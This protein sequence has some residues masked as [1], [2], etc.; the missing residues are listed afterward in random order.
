MRW[1]SLHVFAVLGVAV[2]LAQA[3]AQTRTAAGIEAF[4]RGDYQLAVEILKP[5]AETWSPRD[6]V[7]EFFMATLYE[8]GRGITADPVRACALYVRASFDRENAIGL[9]AAALVESL[10]R[11]LSPEGFRQCVQLANI[12]FEHGFQPVTFT[13][14]QGHWIS[15][16]LDGATVTF[17][18]TDKRSNLPLALSGVVF[19]PVEHT[20][21]TVGRTLSTRRHFI[22]FSMWLP[23]QN[24]QW[25]LIWRVFEVV[26]HDLVPITSAT[27][28]TISGERPTT[29]LSMDV[30]GMARLRVN[31]RG[32]PE[33]AVLSG[34]DQRSEVIES[35]AER[36]EKAEQTREGQADE[37]RVEWKRRSDTRRAPTLIYADADGCANVFMYGWSGDRTEAIAIRA[38]KDLLGLSTAPRM[39]DLA[40][41][42]PGLDLLVH[43]YE[44]PVRSWPFCTDAGSP[45]AS[46]ETWRAT[47]GTVTI[48]L[49]PRGVRARSPFA[50]RATIRIVGA[51]FVNAAG[52]RVKQVQPITL[53]AIVGWM[54]G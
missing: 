13:L 50:Y 51:E 41:Q 14:E 8:N 45:H 19:L 23:G 9:Q 40:S 44:Q 5:L 2:S 47:R 28:A 25:M 46:E 34:P 22:E 49:S 37:A 53:S 52:V 6:H 39:F 43:V 38:D 27:L 36:R 21:L 26:R 29:G 30:H 24:G 15:L 11:S 32:D 42:Q 20:E 17:D 31:D 7:A 4:V 10:H 1:P 54:T 18:G 35:D 33:W 3:Q 16:D 48:E 12:G